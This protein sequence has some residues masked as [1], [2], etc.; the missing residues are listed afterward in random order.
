MHHKE[1][2]NFVNEHAHNMHLIVG[3]ACAIIIWTQMNIVKIQT[4]CRVV[5]D[6]I[7]LVQKLVLYDA[8]MSQLQPLK[9]CH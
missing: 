4:W 7:K 2:V 1:E 5:Y 8:C 9:V 6:Y 3:H